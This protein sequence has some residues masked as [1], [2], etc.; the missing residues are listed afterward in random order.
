MPFSFLKIKTVTVSLFKHVSKL[1]KV[2]GMK[3]KMA[4][5][6]L[7]PHCLM[8]TIRGD[9]HSNVHRPARRV[10]AP[11]HVWLKFTTSFFS[12]GTRWFQHSGTQTERH[13]EF[14]LKC[15]DRVSK[16]ARFGLDRSVTDALAPSDAARRSDQCLQIM[17]SNGRRPLRAIHQEALP[18]NTLRVCV[19]FWWHK[20]CHDLISMFDRRG[21]GT[22]VLIRVGLHWRPSARR[23][24]GTGVF[25]SVTPYRKS[26][27]TL[28]AGQRVC[29]SV[30]NPQTSSLWEN[31]VE[32]PFKWSKQ[33][34]QQQQQQNK[35]HDAANASI[36]LRCPGVECFLLS[37]QGNAEIF[38]NIEILLE[39]LQG[40]FTSTKLCNT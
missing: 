32:S 12:E 28:P 17:D 7:S 9:S 34:Q 33:K 37:L 18:L 23:V 13:L 10:P 3:K 15:Y 24:T 26:I 6:N 40:L 25:T 29:V 16:R 4:A 19:F 2:A 35:K 14:N 5:G 8:N 36:Q 38:N 11:F 20:L 22:A 30:F 31:V 1:F 21:H 27:Y 39:W